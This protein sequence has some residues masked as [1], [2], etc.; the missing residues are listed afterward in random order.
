[1]ALKCLPVGYSRRILR[2][3]TNVHQH[4]NPTARHQSPYGFRAQALV[5]PNNN[6]NAIAQ[7]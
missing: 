5:I 4:A 6:A 7:V 2:L 1:M 3:F